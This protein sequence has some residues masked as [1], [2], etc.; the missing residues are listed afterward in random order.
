MTNS[1]NE[2]IPH[3]VH[4]IPEL[5][6]PPID[7]MRFSNLSVTVGESSINI[8][9]ELRDIVVEGLKDMKFI[10]SKLDFDTG[11]FENKIVIPRINVKC[12]YHFSGHIL[13]FEIDGG[14][15]AE[16]NANDISATLT[17]FG[18]YHTK[19]GIKYIKFG[20][21]DVKVDA[22]DVSVRFDDLFRNNELLTQTVNQAINDNIQTLKEELDSLIGKTIEEV[23]FKGYLKIFDQLPFDVLF[24]N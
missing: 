23:I 7:P 24:P 10:E 17:K 18:N 12:Q 9:A 14:A 4:G 8:K 15:Q 3:L 19:N 21:S 5:N 13:L 11:I 20:K 6:F 1:A 16:L 2:L 22:K